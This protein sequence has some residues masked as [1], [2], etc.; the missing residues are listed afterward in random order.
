[1]STVP[2]AVGRSPAP[3]AAP[4]RPHSAPSEQLL[5]ERAAST[6][7]A[8][9]YPLGVYAATRLLF[10]ALA[11]IDTQ[12]RGWHLGWELSNWDGFWYLLLAWQGY[13]SH[14]LATQST[15]GFLPL[16][17]LLLSGLQHGLSISPVLAGMVVATLSGALATVLVGRLALDWWGEA[18]SRRAVLLLCLFP[19]AIVFSMLYT[20]GLL[21]ALVAGCLL[22]LSR[23][24]WV[25]AGLLAGA[26]TAVGPVALAAIPACAVAAG[27]ELRRRGWRDREARRSLLAP[28]LAP[29]GIVIFGIY[30]WIHTGDP[31]ASYVAQHEPRGWDESSSPLALVWVAGHFLGQLVHVNLHHPK[32]NLNYPSGLLGACFL[33]VGLWW[34]IRGREGRPP[35]PVRTLSPGPA[36]PAPALAYTLG[37]ALLTLT[38]S[39]VPPNPRMLITAF[40]VVV[41]Y[42][43]RL[44]GRAWTR[45]LVL[46]LG[47]TVAMSLVTYVG[48]GLRP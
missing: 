20:E 27:Q 45:A 41:V 47:L 7:A 29:L 15:L 8:V 25:T 40:P 37:V 48:T 35:I 28:L 23:R 36:I 42:A 22:A 30:L 26:A 39:N 46:T 17:P 21:I 4:T 24:R 11:L 3:R 9:R 14:V 2:E 6:W 33:L 34:L 13:P 43:Q 10:L 1:M 32:I 12:L 18:A 38:S 16:Y 5:R 44:Q 31:L 19:G